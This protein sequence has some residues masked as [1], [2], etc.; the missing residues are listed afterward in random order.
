M[1]AGFRTILS[2][3]ILAC[4]AFLPIHAQLACSQIKI[5]LTQVPT[6][7]DWSPVKGVVSSLPIGD[8]F[9][10]YK[11]ALYNLVGDQWWTK[12]SAEAP[13]VAVSADGTFTV[14]YATNNWDITASAI[15]VF[16]LRSMTVTPVALGLYDTPQE[17]NTLAVASVRVPRSNLVKFSGYDMWAIKDTHGGRYEPGQN[18]WSSGGGSLLR[19]DQEGLHLNINKVNGAWTCPEL[20][21]QQALGYGTYVFQVT[22]RV[23]TL[24]AN[25]VLGL[26]VFDYAES[27]RYQ[28]WHELDFEFSRWNNAGDPTAAQFV[29]QPF[30]PVGHTK[31]VALSLNNTFQDVTCVMKW[32]PTQVTWSMYYGLWPNVA[33]NTNKNP[34]IK[35]ATFPAANLI[36]E[37]VFTDPASLFPPGTSWVH[38]NYWL[39][40]PSADTA[41]YPEIIIR[42]FFFKPLVAPATCPT[43]L[44]LSSSSTGTTNPLTSSSS[45][46]NKKKRRAAKATSQPSL[47]RVV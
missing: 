33:P 38:L 34:T 29:I 24:P 44:S 35:A 6:I 8:S 15:S 7:G 3:I 46:V 13:T 9:S 23:D 18:L 5:N 40:L 20:Y 28:A 26:F 14:T 30:E 1:L 39:S 41:T 11:V 27:A 17:L 45:G 43:P 32:E 37:Y 19:V 25:S 42:N 2:L 36:A 10:N 21:L 16:L 22:G 31:R 47:N 12:P 4:V